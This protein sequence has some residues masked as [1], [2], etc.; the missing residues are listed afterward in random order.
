MLLNL[1][2]RKT[3]QTDGWTVTLSVLS[4]LCDVSQSVT[5]RQ[6]L[7]CLFVTDCKHNC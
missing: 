2:Y 4:P 3:S 1:S 6:N 7:V 5:T